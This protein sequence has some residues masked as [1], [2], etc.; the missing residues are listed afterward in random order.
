MEIETKVDLCHICMLIQE[1]E[2]IYS[3]GP[4]V[5]PQN[6]FPIDS[7]AF[8]C[9]QAPLYCVVSGFDN[10]YFD[11]VVKLYGRCAHCTIEIKI[12]FCTFH[13]PQFKVLPIFEKVIFPLTS[14]VTL[15]K[16]CQKN[17]TNFLNHCSFKMHV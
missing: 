6:L 15:P 4:K 8:S 7:N 10:D 3:Q 16:N 5:F 14:M 13:I 17:L 11:F 1:K 2:S 12:C 9:L